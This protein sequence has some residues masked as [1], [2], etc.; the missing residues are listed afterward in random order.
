M[1]KSLL[2]AAIIALPALASAQLNGKAI[3]TTVPEWVQ[4]Q[5][6]SRLKDPG[7]HLQKA[8]TN[9]L[10][11]LACYT[12]SALILTSDDANDLDGVREMGAGVGVIGFAFQISSAIHLI[13]AGKSWE[14][15][16]R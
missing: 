16:N 8:G 12:L 10:Y 9:Q 13:R 5:P 7:T 3:E 6:N 1:K 15:Q 14:D 4:E 2:I 11:A